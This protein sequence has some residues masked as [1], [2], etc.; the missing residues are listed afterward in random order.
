MGV[1]VSRVYI[2]NKCAVEQWKKSARELW[3]NQQHTDVF[4]GKPISEGHIKGK[5]KI[6]LLYH[7]VK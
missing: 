2:N 3:V 6:L 4:Y 7:K 5:D 1:R